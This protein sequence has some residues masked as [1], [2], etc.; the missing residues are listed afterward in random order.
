MSAE[1][2]RRCKLDNNIT[3]TK[4]DAGEFLDSEKGSIFHEMLE[5]RIGRRDAET[6][7]EWQEYRKDA[8]IDMAGFYWQTAVPGCLPDS[9]PI[10]PFKTADDAEDNAT[11]DY[12][13]EK[14]ERL[15]NGATVWQCQMGAARGKFFWTSEDNTNCAKLNGP[16]DHNDEDL[17]DEAGVTADGYENHSGEK[18]A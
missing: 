7:K 8:A 12:E 16:F 17:R 13:L 11:G 1:F 5:D 15:P 3:I 4:Y 10:G 9:D 6:D 18:S 2:I 14:V